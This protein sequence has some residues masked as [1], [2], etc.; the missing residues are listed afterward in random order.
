MAEISYR[1]RKP[2]LR[3]NSSASLQSGRASPSPLSSTSPSKGSR[4]KKSFG[5]DSDASIWPSLP[6]DVLDNLEGRLARINSIGPARSSPHR[7]PT[8]RSSRGV[9]SSG[10]DCGESK[11]TMLRCRTFGDTPGGTRRHSLDVDHQRT[12]PSWERSSGRDFSLE[13][14]AIEDGD[15]SNSR[16]Q[17][18]GCLSAAN[19]QHLQEH[20]D[21]TRKASA[22]LLRDG[23]W[24]EDHA[25]VDQHQGPGSMV[26]IT[27]PSGLQPKDVPATSDVMPQA[28]MRAGRSSTSSGIDHS[29]PW[30]VS[31]FPNCPGKRCE[32]SI[33]L[34]CKSRTGM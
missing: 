25:D 1:R 31:P 21:G 28:R 12:I 22:L 30:Q 4:D 24:M 17:V 3:G 13:F 27:I 15:L 33:T 20:Q 2:S 11:P 6:S 32:I 23:T 29:D 26:D 34:K 18:Q 9:R 7:G 5:N 14:D 16:H 8:F 19:L 10:T